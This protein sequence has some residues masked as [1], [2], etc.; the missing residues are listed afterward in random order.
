MSSRFGNNE[1]KWASS[2]GVQYGVN[3]VR[4]RSVGDRCPKYHVS[5]GINTVM[6][7]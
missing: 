3:R 7:K 5:F 1:M 6:Y 4:D 2:R